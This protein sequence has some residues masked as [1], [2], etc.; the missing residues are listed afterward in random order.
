M[1]KKPVKLKDGEIL[2][3]GLTGEAVP[4]KERFIMRKPVAATRKAAGKTHGVAITGTARVSTFT[5]SKST[6][7]NIRIRMNVI[8]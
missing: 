2:H 6:S 1:K 3:D 5:L 7:A 4:T 8:T